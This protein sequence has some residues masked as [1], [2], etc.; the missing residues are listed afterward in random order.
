[1]STAEEF[2]T[3]VQ[4]LLPE[5]Q[6]LI[7]Q[8]PDLDR[9]HEEWESRLYHTIDAYIVRPALLDRTPADPPALTEI[10]DQIRGMQIVLSHT[11]SGPWSW[12]ARGNHPAHRRELPVLE[13]KLRE[14][15]E[16]I[17]ESTLAT[18]VPQPRARTSRGPHPDMDRH[19]KIAGVIAA[20]GEEWKQDKNLHEIV[21]KLD[22]ARVA[23]S[24]SWLKRKPAARS[25]K[26]AQLYFAQDVVKA[27]DYSLKMVEHRKSNRS[28]MP[29]LG[30]SR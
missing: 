30:N 29:T 4:K 28:E 8:M 10:A 11:L 9:P 3:D 7:A 15:L 21:V 19:E 6:T 1:M 5:V 20:F 17:P 22:K 27:I 23:V 24:K 2:R 16:Y 26:T 25:W 13:T 14:L 18:A 12:G